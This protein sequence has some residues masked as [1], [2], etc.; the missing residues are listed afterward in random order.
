[1]TTLD[2]IFETLAERPDLHVRSS[3]LYRLFQATARTA[4]EQLFEATERAAQPFGPFGSL[5]MPYTKM[6]S[7]DS[8]DLFGVDELIIFAFYNANTDTTPDV[9]RGLFSDP[10]LK[11]VRQAKPISVA[12]NWTAALQA[13]RGDYAVTFISDS[14]TL[15]EMSVAVIIGVGSDIGRELALDADFVY[16]SPE[17]GVT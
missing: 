11:V 3:A 7:I 8:L 10:R 6:G 1:M 5:S 15:T 14:L 12:E 17:E 2:L 16:S 13:S 4:I 9:I